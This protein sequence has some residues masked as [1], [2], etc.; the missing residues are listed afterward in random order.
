MFFENIEDGSSE[1]AEFEELIRSVN[2]NCGA[3]KAKDRC[4]NALEFAK[5]SD[6]VIESFH[7]AG[8]MLNIDES[9]GAAEF[10]K[11]AY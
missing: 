6:K 1:A 4:D 3:L 10:D 8:N 7:I 2:E 5:C 9:H 11:E